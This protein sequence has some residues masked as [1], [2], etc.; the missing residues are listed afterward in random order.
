[1]TKG[2]SCQLQACCILAV[3]VQQ[4]CTGSPSYRILVILAQLKKLESEKLHSHVQTITFK[5]LV[6][7]QEAPEP[8]FPS[9]DNSLRCV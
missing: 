5:K 6:I 9:P 3:L 8:S 4:F 7:I 2:I 1:M